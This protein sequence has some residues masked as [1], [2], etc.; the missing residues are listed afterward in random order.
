MKH[1]NTALVITALTLGG[2]GLGGSAVADEHGMKNEMH[3]MG[4]HH[5][6]DKRCWRATLTDEQSKQLDQLRLAYKQKV[7]PLKAKIK[8]A[9][10]ELAL[11]VSTDDPSQKAIDKKIDEIV[12]MKAEN[13]RLKTA[14]QVEVRKLLTPEQ[15]VSYDMKLLKK[16][17][18]D[19][20]GYHHGGGHH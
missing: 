11:L 17:S 14:H 3:E 18:R 1:I 8:Q 16:A 6:T 4:R 7:S 2:V 19:R 10:I 15:R 13:M 5:G 12:T 20:K 9:R